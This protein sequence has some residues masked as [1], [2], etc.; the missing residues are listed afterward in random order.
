MDIYYRSPA[1]AREHNE[2]DLFRASHRENV[3]CSRVID[4][5]IAASFDGW[6]LARHCLADILEQYDPARVAMILATTVTYKAWDGRI[7]RDNKKWAE[8]IKLPETIPGGLANS[9][10]AYLLDTHPAVLDGFVSM[11]RKEVKI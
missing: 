3:N 11:F 4:K 7:S 1:Y 8:G 9:F 6:K 5:A 2:S 10:T